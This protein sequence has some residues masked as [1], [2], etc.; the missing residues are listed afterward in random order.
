M[1][2]RVAVGQNL[3]YYYD[4]VKACRKETM[5]RYCICGG[6][7]VK[8]YKEDCTIKTLINRKKYYDS[9]GKSILL[10]HP[11]AKLCNT[12]V[13]GPHITLPEPEPPVVIPTEPQPTLSPGPTPTWP[14][15]TGK[16]ESDIRAYCENAIRNSAVGRACASISN[17]PSHL[18]IEQCI[19]NVQV[20]TEIIKY[21]RNNCNQWAIAD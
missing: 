19:V 5:K 10:L 14:A 15:T 12:K 11:T 16:N 7:S 6:A 2:H 8:G 4:G 3:F 17:F 18:Y 9:L 21:S 1:L 20:N 13:E